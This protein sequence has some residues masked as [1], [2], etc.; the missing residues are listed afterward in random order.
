MMN[1]IVEIM[2]DEMPE[3]MQEAINEGRLASAAIEKTE[4]QK[5]T[6]DALNKVVDTSQDVINKAEICIEL[7]DWGDSDIYLAYSEAFMV[8]D[9]ALTELQDNE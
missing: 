7:L 6:I 5:A 1:N 8:H 9:K 4:Q 2:P 3:W